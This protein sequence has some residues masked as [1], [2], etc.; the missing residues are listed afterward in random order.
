MSTF[1]AA[2]HVFGGSIFHPTLLPTIPAVQLLRPGRR[3]HVF[4]Q[5]QQRE[6]PQPI[7]QNQK[8]MVNKKGGLINDSLLSVLAKAPKASVFFATAKWDSDWT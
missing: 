1:L 5:L 4:Q 7:T 8:N 2:L 3:D 6:R